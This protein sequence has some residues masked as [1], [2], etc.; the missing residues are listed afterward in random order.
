MLR[1]TLLAAALLLL[2]ACNR[3]TPQVNTLLSEGQPLHVEGREVSAGYVAIRL[4]PLQGEEPAA[5]PASDDLVEADGT[6]LIFGREGKGVPPGRYRVEVLQYDPY[7]RDKLQGRFSREK[8]P[9]E[10]EV[11]PESALQIDLADYAK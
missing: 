3:Y 2:P 1:I 10:I 9:I 4:Y 6:F 7:P 11:T 5:E 8:S